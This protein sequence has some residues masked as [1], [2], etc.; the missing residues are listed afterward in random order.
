MKSLLRSIF[1]PAKQKTNFAAD[2]FDLDS[3]SRIF[4]S[5]IKPEKAW[6]PKVIDNHG[7]SKEITNQGR[8]SACV[9]HTLRNMLEIWHLY[10]H[11]SIGGFDADKIYEGAKDFQGNTLPGTTFDYGIKSCIKLGYL[12]KEYPYYHIVGFDDINYAMAKSFCVPIGLHISKDWNNVDPKTGWIPDKDSDKLGGHA[13]L[14]VLWDWV[15]R[16]FGLENS[17]KI[18]W[19][20]QGYGQMD[21]TKLN[22]E[23]IDALWCPIP[24]K[25]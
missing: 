24:E 20:M 25:F 3:Y 7:W 9:G 18:G 17:W 2:G 23:K 16:R 15:G 8:T 13:V 10:F 11:S 4:S 22:R 5:R 12:P 14:G 6:T 19:G 1:G 21:L